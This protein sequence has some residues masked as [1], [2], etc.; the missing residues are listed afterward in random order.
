MG[1]DVLQNTGL[2][3]SEDF[4]GVRKLNSLLD[5]SGEASLSLIDDF[6]LSM[7]DLISS[8]YFSKNSG[9]T[10]WL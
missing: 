10:T 5:F 2:S 1:V 4:S 3:S 6:V 7:L 8:T 9:G